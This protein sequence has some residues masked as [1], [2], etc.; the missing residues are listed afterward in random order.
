MPE[1]PDVTVYLEALDARVRG[2]ELRNVR[3]ASPFV[4]R[5]FDPPI[6]AAKGLC[7]RELRRVGKRLAFRLSTDN[8][9]SNQFRE[10]DLWLVIHLMI[11]GRFKWLP[12]GAKVP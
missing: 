6:S 1:L 5:T 10:S 8:L 4:V 3:L 12:L 2:A 9:D 11:S 7:V